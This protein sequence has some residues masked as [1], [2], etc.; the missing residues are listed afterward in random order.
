MHINVVHATPHTSSQHGKEHDGFVA[1]LEIIGQK[2][3]VRWVNVHPNNPDFRSQERLI[4]DCDFLLIRSDWEWIPA[5]AADRALL[6][7]PNLPAGLV[8]A[9]S[10]P[11]P[12]L[13]LQKRYDC[14]AYETEWYAPFVAEHPYSFQAFGVD[15]TFMRNFQMSERP[16]DWLMVGRLAGFK[17]PLAL[18]GKKGYRIAIGD[19]SSADER[20]VSSLRSSGV[21]VRDFVPYPELA[22]LY[23][24]SKNVLVPCEL[25]GGGERAVLEARA[26]GC[27]VEV[28]A[29]NPKLKSLLDVPVT[30]HMQYADKLL[31]SI[32]EVMN[33]RRIPVDEKVAALR[34]ARWNLYSDKIRRTRQTVRIRARGLLDWTGVVNAK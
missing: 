11:A 3:D 25:Q 34:H 7:A 16:W 5:R 14:L 32:A 27:S 17:R 1:A 9:G 18:C 12:A 33:G 10:S 24:L 23:N 29:D 22:R 31:T 13:Q 2:H 28:A 8:I 15:T 20:T 4:G 30:D 26:C 6:K 19:M 21:E